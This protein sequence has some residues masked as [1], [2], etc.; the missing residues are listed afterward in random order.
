MWFPTA[1]TRAWVTPLMPS[2]T[3]PP[4]N[5]IFS[6]TGACGV[7][8]Y[9]DGCGRLFGWLVVVILWIGGLGWARR[10]IFLQT[11]CR[12]TAFLSLVVATGC[13]S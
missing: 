12:V 9:R 5:V 11:L 7:K 6:Y 4:V 3:H 13:D 8:V 10:S 2:N 1:F